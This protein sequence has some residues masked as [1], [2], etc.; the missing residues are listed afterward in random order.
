M[1]EAEK[2]AQAAGYSVPAGC[3]LPADKVFLLKS[4]KKNQKGN[5]LKDKLGT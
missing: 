1:L 2:L 4:S 5:R 3:G